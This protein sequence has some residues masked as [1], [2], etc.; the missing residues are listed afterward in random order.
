MS[1]TPDLD[2][3]RED[4]D[5]ELALA[6]RCLSAEAWQVQV[7]LHVAGESHAAVVQDQPLEGCGEIRELS[8]RF[9]ILRGSGERREVRLD[10]QP[11][12]VPTSYAQATGGYEL[13][14]EIVG[15]D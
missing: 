12:V 8:E 11:S 5:E 2:P 7:H 3:G 9:A 6:E 10:L 14:E 15:Q 13:S 4:A 1:T